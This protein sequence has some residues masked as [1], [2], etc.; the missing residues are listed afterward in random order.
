MR[1]IADYTLGL[2]IVMGHLLMIS[3]GARRRLQTEY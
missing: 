3:F 1:A 2:A